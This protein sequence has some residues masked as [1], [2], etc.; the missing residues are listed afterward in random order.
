MRRIG[1]GAIAVL[2]GLGAPSAHATQAGQQA[3]RNWGAMDQCAKD[4]QSAFPDY[5]ADAYAK[6]D[7]KLKECLEG[8]NL[9]P[10]SPA[11]N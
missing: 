6:R 1:A 7:A 10:R 8:K 11:G 3:I 5:S 9:P 4:A 2:L